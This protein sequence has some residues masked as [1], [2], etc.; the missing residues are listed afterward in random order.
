LD[1][2][3]SHE[4]QAPSKFIVSS[5]LQRFDFQ[6]SSSACVASR[7]PLHQTVARTVCL[8]VPHSIFSATQRSAGS[9][10]HLTAVPCPSAYKTSSYGTCLRHPRRGSCK[11][12]SPIP[13]FQKRARTLLDA[14]TLKPSGSLKISTILSSVYGI[15]TS[16]SALSSGT[17]PSYPSMRTRHSSWATCHTYGRLYTTLAVRC[18]LLA[19]R[20]QRV[21]PFSLRHPF[22]WCQQ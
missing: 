21:L 15:Y 22:G 6:A 3:S 8:D 17:S 1:A 10:R 13:R 16:K 18:Y 14:S 12:L 11:S 2:I 4:A 19:W 5:V 9:H 7:Q 20:S